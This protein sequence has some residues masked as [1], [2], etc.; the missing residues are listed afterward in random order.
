ML[1]FNNPHRARKR[2]KKRVASVVRRRKSR[3]RSVRRLT[4][5]STGGNM[6]R[7]KRARRATRVSR[8][9][10]RRTTTTAVALQRRGRTVYR[11]NPRRRRRHRSYG[12]NP[13]FGGILGTLKNGIKDGA[14]V[15]A[16][17]I[18]A[19]KV[20][21]LVDRVNPIG[22]IA[23]DAI[24]GL[25][26]AVA[27]SFLARKFAPNYSRLIAAAAFAQGLRKILSSTPV[28][29]YLSSYESLGGDAQY[30]AYQEVGSGMSAWPGAAASFG[31]AGEDVMVQ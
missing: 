14:V 16:G 6:A 13:S 2:S 30:G 23:G 21:N 31:D 18:A 4:A 27:V 7:R 12:R 25:G 11:S 24:N 15:L 19:S 5:R 28:A 3:R 22:G 10:R 8:R 29:P 26:G 20:I 17:E 1:F 9:R